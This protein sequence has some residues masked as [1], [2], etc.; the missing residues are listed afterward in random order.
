M[1]LSFS[2]KGWHDTSFD[3]FCSIACDLN[4]KGIELHNISNNLFTDKDS[5]FHDYTASS[6]RRKLFNMKLEIPCIDSICDIAKADKAENA[7]D[8][9]KK[10]IDIADTIK[11]PFVRIKAHEGEE[12]TVENARK[13][14]EKVLPYACEKSVTMLVETSGIFAKSD[15]LRDFLDSFA[16]DNLGALWDLSLAYFSC[17]EQPKDV[18]DS[19]NYITDEEFLDILKNWLSD[20]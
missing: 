19:Y 7:E 13:T 4:F 10:C 11:I 12:D 15:V 1:K 3:E 16:S 17:F 20:K 9:I 14:V 2:T 8:E 18:I 5:A 6:T